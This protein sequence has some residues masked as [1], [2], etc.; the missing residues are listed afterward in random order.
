[1]RL[2]LALFACMCLLGIVPFAATKAATK[3]AVPLVCSV[4]G[5]KLMSGGVS[6]DE[7]CIQIATG[8]SRAINTPIRRVSELS[9]ASRKSGRWLTVN[10]RLTKP[11][12]ASTL[13]SHR[14]NG[15]IDVHPEFSI[16]ISD[17]ALDVTVIDQI[18]LE[19][20]KKLKR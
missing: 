6:A 16:S 5:A 10:V 12:T 15:R 20:S 11:A 13:F 8:L 17:R 18:V 1:M 7:I 4:S 2:W 9:S 19:M 3:V 14:L